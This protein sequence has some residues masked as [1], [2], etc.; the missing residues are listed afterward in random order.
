MQRRGL[1]EREALYL[2]FTNRR[3]GN[4]IPIFFAHV[5]LTVHTG[6]PT[7]LSRWDAATASNHLVIL[8]T[9]DEYTFGV[10]RG[11]WREIFRK[12][13][14][15]ALRE[16]V[17]SPSTG[18]QESKDRLQKH[19]NYWEHQSPN[20]LLSLHIEKEIPRKIKINRVPLVRSS[21]RRYWSRAFDIKGR[22]AGRIRVEFRN[23]LLFEI[24]AKLMKMRGW[25]A[26]I[27]GEDVDVVCGAPALTISGFQYQGFIFSEIVPQNGWR[28][29]LCLR[30]LLTPLD[31]RNVNFQNFKKHHK[32]FIYI[33]LPAG[34]RILLR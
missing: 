34:H 26:D 16:L 31:L 1:R 22:W 8:Q 6:S 5:L 24:M 30:V 10:R 29:R 11:K 12:K 14:L 3:P 7:I 13:T 32:P 17:F 18:L 2:C 20:F 19:W 33:F 23:S 4:L 27:E 15:S 28:D 21:E 25:K 9:V